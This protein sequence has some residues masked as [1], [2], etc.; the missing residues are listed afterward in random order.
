[1]LFSILIAT[2]GERKEQFKRLYQKLSQQ[3]Q[4]NSLEGEAEIV[5][6]LDN[7]EHS[8][9]FK[10]NRLIEWAKGK[11]VAFVD[12]DDEV[13]DDYVQLICQVLKANPHI[14]CIGI[15][16]IITFAGEKPHIF[17]H[18]VQYRDYFTRGGT[19][20]RPPYCLNPIRREIACRYRFDDISYSEDIDWAMRMCQEQ[21]L[22]EE[23]FIDKAIYHYYS[24]RLWIY[25]MLL[26]RSERLRHALGLRLVNRLRLKRWFKSFYE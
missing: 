23:Y 26:D 1:M 21:A 10:R 18:S 17:I 20:F 25:Q 6:F 24:R 5:W 4:E 8:V 12:D 16:G 19:Y 13:S 9:G 22:R 7:K 3:I 11:F 14:D 2:I 15:T